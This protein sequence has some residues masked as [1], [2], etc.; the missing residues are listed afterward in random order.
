MTNHDMH[1][2]SF[3]TTTIIVDDNEEFLKSIDLKLDKTRQSYKYFTNAH[4]AT[5]FIKSNYYKSKWF[6]KY[7]QNIDESEQDLK[8]VEFNLKDLHKQVYDKDRFSIITTVIS[9]YDMPEI[10]GL[11]MFSDLHD[12]QLHKVLL[13]GVVDEKVAVKAFNDKAIDAFIPK[14]HSDIYSQIHKVIRDGS[15]NYFA[16][17]GDKLLEPDNKDL[18]TSIYNNSVFTKLFNNLMADNNIVEYYMTSTD[19]SFLLIS[20][21]GQYSMLFIY[22]EAH[23]ESLSLMAKEEDFTPR[24]QELLDAKQKMLCFYGSNEQ[25]IADWNDCQKYLQDCTKVEI[26]GTNYY[27]SHVKNIGLDKKVTG[28]AAKI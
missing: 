18:F 2:C 7:I 16:N 28:F 8:L 10:T 11:E 6:L 27:Y 4:E 23:L 14:S 9:D 5:R 21:N 15:N 19:G 20:N 22:S 17:I 25:T 12:A 24:Y 1:I 3:P 26:S 13:T